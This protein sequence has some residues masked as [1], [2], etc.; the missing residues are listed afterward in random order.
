MMPRVTVRREAEGRADG[1]HGL[2]RIE[3][4]AVAKLGVVN[5]RPRRFTSPGRA[6]ARQVG[7]VVPADELG[8]DALEAGQGHVDLDGARAGDMGVGQDEAVGREDH[9]RA[10]A[11]GDALRAVLEGDFA[12]VDADH[13]VEHRLNP[14]LIAARRVTQAATAPR[15]AAGSMIDREVERF[16]VAG[17]TR[18]LPIAKTTTF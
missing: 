8:A 4:V 18:W 13:G 14:R 6:G 7:P 12:H 10:D 5:L 2:A 11:G 17:F 15:R 1:I 3:F 9:A 16:T